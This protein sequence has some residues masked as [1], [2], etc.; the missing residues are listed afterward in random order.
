MEGNERLE[1]FLSLVTD[2]KSD[3]LARVK[4]RVDNQS[5]IK[6][7]Q[8]IAITILSTLRNNRKEGKTP[9]TQKELAETL[10][11]SPQQINKIVK[12]QE[13]LTLETISRLELALEIRLIEIPHSYAITTS[14]KAVTVE[15]NYTKGVDSQISKQTFSMAETIVYHPKTEV[16]ETN[17]AMA[18]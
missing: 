7:S 14:Y 12:G 11:I 3:F 18:A 13:N 16:G 4:W 2:S 6:R 9:A 17:Y 10:G 5:W 8:A 1:K 15:A